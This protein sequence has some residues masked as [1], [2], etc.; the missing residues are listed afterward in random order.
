V[1]Q[2]TERNRGR[3]LPREDAGRF[4]G[5]PSVESDRWGLEE[6]RVE[7]PSQDQNR[8]DILI[9]VHELVEITYDTRGPHIARV[10]RAGHM[11]RPQRISDVPH[12]LLIR[13]GGDEEADIG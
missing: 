7:S 1:E 9:F 3:E 6:L 10:R 11:A 4:W 5:K 2:P 12:G 8:L 13:P